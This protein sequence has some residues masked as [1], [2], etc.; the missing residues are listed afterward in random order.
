M[1]W[2]LLSQLPSTLSQALL[3]SSC[4]QGHISK[5]AASVICTSGDNDSVAV[6]MTHLHD[7][8]EPV[9]VAADSAVTKTFSSAAAWVR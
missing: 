1:L 8:H 2:C 4:D 7:G 9:H 6:Q 5:T 3:G